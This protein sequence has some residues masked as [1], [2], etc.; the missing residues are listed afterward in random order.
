MILQT[1]LTFH[2]HPNV[3]MRIKKETN[4]HLPKIFQHKIHCNDGKDERKEN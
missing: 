2:N 1:E 4:L 3:K